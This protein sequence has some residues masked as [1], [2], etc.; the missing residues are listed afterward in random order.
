MLVALNNNVCCLSPDLLAVVAVNDSS[1]N[2]CPVPEV[3]TKVNQQPAQ[4]N[5][6]HLKLNTI[7][8]R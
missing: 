4:D 6:L 7:Q 1:L 3:E 5:L 8:N 2:Y